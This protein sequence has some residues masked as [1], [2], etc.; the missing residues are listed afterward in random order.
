MEESYDY[1][2]LIGLNVITTS[3]DE[4]GPVTDILPGT[5]N[6]NL[7]I[8]GATGEILI[9]FIEDVVISVDLKKKIV[10]IEAIDGL[11]D[12]NMKKQK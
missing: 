9:P 1:D 11:L 10:T 3:G 8:N 5:A 12:L 2:E 7:I 4:I 6:D